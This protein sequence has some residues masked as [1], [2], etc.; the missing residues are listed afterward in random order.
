MNGNDQASLWGTRAASELSISLRP[1][2]AIA[3]A[4]RAVQRAL[5][6]GTALTVQSAAN[7]RSEVGAVLGSTLS[8][9]NDTTIVVLVATIVSVL[10]LMIAAIWQRRERLDSLTAMGLSSWDFARLVSYESGILLLSGCVVG[11]AFGL[12]GQFLIDGWLH[13]TTGASLQYTPAW[14]LGLRTLLITVGICAAACMLV[15]AQ[16]AAARRFEGYRWIDFAT[17]F[18]GH[19]DD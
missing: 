7:R 2:T 8:R 15:V 14:A 6:A 5:P 12:L 16:T 4:E 13:D 9:L 10:T 11:A 1:G 3:P 19:K 18:R 17:G